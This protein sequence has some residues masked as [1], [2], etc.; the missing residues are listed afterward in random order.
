MQRFAVT[1]AHWL[2]SLA[3]AVWF[4]GIITLG[5]IVAPAAFGVD[6]S[7][8]A[9][10]LEECFRKLNTVAFFCGAIMLGATWA[11]AQIRSDYAR[12]LLIVRAVLTAAAVALGL[13][14]GI[15]LLPM[16]INLRAEGQLDEFNRLHHLYGLVTR[17]QFGLLAAGGLISAYLA[18][19]RRGSS[20]ARALDAAPAA[21]SPIRTIISRRVK[22]R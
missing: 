1:L 21:P 20:K 19:P 4:G 3:F 8:A 15:R 9:T 17:V 14:L 7:F 10:V 6:R 18:L 11:E 13:Y 12:R 5:A 2:H 16:L 22:Q